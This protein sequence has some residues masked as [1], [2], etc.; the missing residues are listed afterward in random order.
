MKKEE[1]LWLHDFNIEQVLPVLHNLRE[2]DQLETEASGF[3]S[4]EYHSD[5]IEQA[6]DRATI[7]WLGICENKPICVGGLLETG[8]SVLEGWFLASNWIRRRHFIDIT[9]KAC[10]ILKS[11]SNT[12]IRVLVWNQHIISHK[13]LGRLGFHKAGE[14]ANPQTGEI[15]FQYLRKSNV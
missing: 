5:L 8:D 12:D 4:T 9:D 2:H 6:L 13:W 11:F 3:N 15:F 1:I 14:A 10:T 7:K